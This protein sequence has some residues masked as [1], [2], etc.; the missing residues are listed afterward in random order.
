MI[1]YSESNNGM[2]YKHEEF[3]EYAPEKPVENIKK[4]ILV[5]YVVAP[6]L[7]DTRKDA[8][9]TFFSHAFMNLKNIGTLI[10]EHSFPD[11]LEELFT[12]YFFKK[13]IKHLTV[14][15]PK[16]ANLSAIKTLE[17]YTHN[18]RAEDEKQS[19]LDEEIAPH[20][21]ALLASN[22]DTLQYIRLGMCSAAM[23]ELIMSVMGRVDKFKLDVKV[24]LMEEGLNEELIHRDGTNLK[25]IISS[26]LSHVSLAHIPSG[27]ETV[28][29]GF[30]N[31]QAVAFIEPFFLQ[32][33]TLN[34]VVFEMLN[35]TWSPETDP[36]NVL[37]IPFLQHSVAVASLERLT[38]PTL[39]RLNNPKSVQDLVVL[40]ATLHY[41]A[42]QMTEL[43]IKFMKVGTSPQTYARQICGTGKG[44]YDS[45][46]KYLVC[47]FAKPKTHYVPTEE[48]EAEYPPITNFHNAI[49]NAGRQ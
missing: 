34:E 27:L 10:I 49:D 29:V 1:Y 21:I 37:V 46:G 42:Y 16:L 47:T 6:K 25:A 24:D 28:T 13:T 30:T 48:E 39:N 7:T 33:T 19:M 26:P 9:I 4:L 41:Y 14:D 45:K 3:S 36:F 11:I 40:V 22:F 23:Y 43:K 35:I 2:I 18:V 17:S 5:G 20:L 32:H 31:E 15:S 44:K 12:E 8:L 38:I